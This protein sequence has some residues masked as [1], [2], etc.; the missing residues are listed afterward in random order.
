MF[1]QFKIILLVLLFTF[2]IFCSYLYSQ[3]WQPLGLTNKNVRAVAVD[4]QHSNT[5]YAGADNLY[6][7]TDTGATWVS[8]CTSA[9]YDIEINP[10][11]TQ[12]IYILGGGI[13]KTT[14]GGQDWAFVMSG[15]YLNPEEFPIS[16][17]MSSALPDILYSGS[18]GMMGGGLFKTTNGGN[19]WI[20]VGDTVGQLMHSNTEIEI[21]PINSQEVYVGTD[22]NG[23]VLKTTDGGISW[24]STGLSLGIVEDI[25]IDYQN[26]NIL[27]V[28]GWSNGFYKSEDGGLTWLS[29]NAGLPPN[30]RI[31]SIAADCHSDR[32]YLATIDSIYKSD[33]SLIQWKSI[34]EGLSVGIN[35]NTLFFDST[36]SI[37]YCGTN[38]G[39]YKLN[40]V[41]GFSENIYPI[42]NHYKLY[43]NFPNPFNHTTTIRYKIGSTSYVKIFIYNTLGER[44]KSLVDNQQSYGDYRI[45]WDGTNDSG[46]TVNSGVYF[47]KMVVFS[48]EVVISKYMQISKVVFVK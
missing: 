6:R 7:S 36:N 44:V 15:M 29:N 24:I 20:S 43:P 1:F 26:S 2:F 28:G 31:T 39:I 19:Y 21:N 8:I 45:V 33:I 10:Q 37:L 35:I 34:S 27:Y 17:E 23:S 13:L 46:V 38:V 48:K 40:T 11:N 12:I 47:V 30:R 9:V 22:W 14:N 32:L 41:N 5:I 42:T 18:G 3:Q 4:P 16:L 25:E